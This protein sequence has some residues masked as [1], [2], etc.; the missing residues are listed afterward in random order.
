MLNNN[1]LGERW[2]KLVAAWIAFEVHF[3]CVPNGL[4]PCKG[5]PPAVGD[6]PGWRP[7]IVNSKIFG[8]A[9][10]KWWTYLQPEWRVLDDDV[11]DRVDA[12]DLKCLKKPG[13]NGL[14]SILASLFFWGTAVKAAGKK[15]ERW[16][17]YVE[18]FTLV[19][20]HLSST[21]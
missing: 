5:R 15:S 20:K 17:V 12:G 3:K 13:A 6:Y 8:D 16:N 11:F 19:L 21:A 1:T 10:V 18:D 7:I 2:A 4:L 14:L 9:H